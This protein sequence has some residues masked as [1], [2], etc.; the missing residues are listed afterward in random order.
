MCNRNSFFNVLLAL[1]VGAF[2]GIVTAMFLTQD[3]EE[4]GGNKLNRILHDIN[5]KLERLVNLGKKELKKM[6]DRVED[7]AEEVMNKGES[8]SNE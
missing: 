8:L 6:S 3:E 1:F 2:T 4:G 7:K 5:E